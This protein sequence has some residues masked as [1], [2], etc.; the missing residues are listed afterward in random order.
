MPESIQEQRPYLI[1]HLFKYRSIGCL[2][3]GRVDRQSRKWALLAPTPDQ[4]AKL[5][6]ASRSI[7]GKPIPEKAEKYLAR[8]L[9]RR[10]S[11]E[12]VEQL[13][14]RYEKGETISALSSEF[15]ISRPALR[16]LLRGAGVSPRRRGMAPEDADRAIQLFESG[17]TIY[18]VIDQVGY[19]YGV[20]NRMLHKRGVKV[21]PRRN[22]G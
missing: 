2:L 9:K 15:D 11:P 1:E 7:K 6:K 4:L 18:E 3:V 10:L 5:A 14:K 8:N 16:I 12:Q 21:R 13:A 17:L 19:S 22:Q 20:I